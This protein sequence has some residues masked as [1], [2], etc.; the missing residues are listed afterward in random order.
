[1]EISKDAKPFYP[2][3]T[4]D[5]KDGKANNTDSGHNSAGGGGVWAAGS[6]SI[7]QTLND[8]D[9][10]Q[11]VWG[12]PASATRGGGRAGESEQLR[13]TS[14]ATHAQAE[15]RSRHSMSPP[16]T[17]TTDAYKP[18]GRIFP[19]PNQSSPSAYLQV[20]A[21]RSSGASA[22]EGHEWSTVGPAASRR[23]A[24]RGQ[25]HSSGQSRG[26]PANQN[27]PTNNRG[28]NNS[29]NNNRGTNNAGYNQRPAGNVCGR[30]AGSG[31][32][33][34][35]NNKNNSS[36]GGD[37]SY[38]NDTSASVPSA[39]FPHRGIPNMMTGTVFGQAG[40]ANTSDGAGAGAGTRDQK[41]SILDGGG[42]PVDAETAIYDRQS[43]MNYLLDLKNISDALP[44]TSL[45]A[46]QYSQLHRLS[47]LRL[48][49]IIETI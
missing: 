24:G 19:N 17:A 40:H 23:G 44:P 18:T 38:L 48:S 36:G 27:R 7:S 1:M 37:H 31:F 25:G 6:P 2:R 12:T 21:G 10:K 22:G 14:S 26:P 34:A 11:T 13:D 4:K 47:L 15:N 5:S 9:N 20:H 33:N 41:N 49:N 43:M 32:G 46:N 16:L 3:H 29:S 42:N 28:A 35:R 45:N 8:V 39:V 30:A